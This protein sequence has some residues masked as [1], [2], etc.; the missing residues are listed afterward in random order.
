MSPLIIGFLGLPFFFLLDVCLLVCCQA[1]SGKA[2]PPASPLVSSSSPARHCA[3]YMGTYTLGQFS[4]PKC[5]CLR[6]SEQILRDSK[7]F[8]KI[9]LAGLQ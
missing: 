3:E 5:R 8:V 1:L 4:V 6:D 9:Q 7:V 2:A